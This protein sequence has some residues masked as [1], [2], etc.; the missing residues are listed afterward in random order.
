M[1]L[2]AK[3][4][5]NASYRGTGKVYVNEVIVEAQANNIPSGTAVKVIPIPA[6]TIVLAASVEILTPSD[7]ATSA[8][9]VVQIGGNA[10]AT[11]LDLKSAAG[12]V[13]AGNTLRVT[14]ADTTVDLLA[15]YTGTTNQKGRFKV[16]ILCADLS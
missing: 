14:S 10:I 16:S 15:T 1:D 7:A 11:G 3:L 12:V 8:T 9:G 13:Q 4:G 2:T 5:R 6:K